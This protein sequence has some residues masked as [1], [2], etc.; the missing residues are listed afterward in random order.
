MGNAAD[1]SAADRVHVFKAWMQAEDGDG[2][3]RRHIDACVRLGFME[4]LNRAR[5]EF[6]EIGA[7]AARSIDD[8]FQA[9]RFDIITGDIATERTAWLIEADMGFG[10]HWRTEDGRWSR[11]ANE[12]LQFESEGSA[13]DAMATLEIGRPRPTGWIKPTEHKWLCSAQ[14]TDT[15]K[16]R[17]E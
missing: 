12:A 6:T 10:P 11:D 3:E 5:W 4:K 15:T 7:A 2:I 13:A 9:G 17:A 16:E 8:L 1:L 14:A